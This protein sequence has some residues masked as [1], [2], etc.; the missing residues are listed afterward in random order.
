MTTANFVQGQAGSK[1]TG[2][3]AGVNDGIAGTTGI[4]VSIP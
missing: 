2:G 3:V 4:T 1:G